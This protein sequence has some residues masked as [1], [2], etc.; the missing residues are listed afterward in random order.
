M[1]RQPTNWANIFA[2]GNINVA[3]LGAKTAQTVSLGLT[4]TEAVHLIKFRFG[5]ARLSAMTAADGPLIFG[6]CDSS[7]SPSSIKAYIEM[8]PSHSRHDDQ[9]SLGHRGSVIR[10]LGVIGDWPGDGSEMAFKDLEDG[11]IDIRLSDGQSLEAWAYNP[12][13][14]ALGAAGELRIVGQLLGRWLD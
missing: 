3:S 7:Q 2:E 9:L 5:V 6:V 11:K 14:A 12:D 4:I 10:V 1:P 8:N 13:D